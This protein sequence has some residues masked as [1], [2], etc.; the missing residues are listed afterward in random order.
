MR[1]YMAGRRK[2]ATKGCKR[3]ES[4]VR[5]TCRVRHC[6][7]VVEA[8]WCMEI[9]AAAEDRRARSSIVSGLVS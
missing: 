7:T 3:S 1:V 5:E 6:G 8:C 4:Q 2:G 9:A